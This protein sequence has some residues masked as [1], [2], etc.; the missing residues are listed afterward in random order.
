MSDPTQIPVPPALPAPTGRKLKIALAISVAINLCVAG[1]IGGIALHVG[2][3]GHGDMMVRDF[4]FGPFD[5]ALSPDDRDALR[6]AIQGKLG[7]IRA[8]RQQMQADGIAI[9]SALRAD[10]FDKDR[11]GAA[12]DAQSDHLGERLKFGNGVIREFLMGLTPMARADFADRLEHRM[13][14]GRDGGGP[15]ETKD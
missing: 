15:P 5:D 1:L 10:P 4:G 8:A 12:L 9:L 6:G 13:R 3:G 14:R 2:P 7:D 11:L